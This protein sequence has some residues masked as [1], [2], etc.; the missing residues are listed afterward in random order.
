MVANNLSPQSQ[1]WVRDTEKRIKVLEDENKRLAGLISNGNVRLG[2]SMSARQRIDG[3]HYLGHFGTMNQLRNAV[4]FAVVG[5]FCTIGEPDLAQWFFD[6]GMW[7]RAIYADT[8]STIVG[9][10]AG[11]NPYGSNDSE[12]NGVVIGTQA[13]NAA[14][15]FSGIAIGQNTAQQ[16]NSNEG[17][18]IGNLAGFQ[19]ESGQ[20]SSVVIGRLAG[21][22]AT[23]HAGVSIGQL[24]AS[25]AVGLGSSGI[26]IGEYSG[27]NSDNFSGIAIGDNAGVMAKN[28][29]SSGVFVGLF[30]G[31]NSEDNYNVTY[32]G[33][34][35]GRNVTH[36]QDVIGFGEYAASDGTDLQS[37]IAI[38]YNAVGHGGSFGG[39]RRVIAIG[40]N[41]A[42]LGPT[43]SFGVALT[44]TVAVGDNAMFIAA[45]D[46]V[47]VGVGSAQYSGGASLITAVGRNAA[48][49]A[50]SGVN[51]TAIGAYALGNSGA[52]TNA[53]ALGVNAG[54]TDGT[55]YTTPGLSYATLIG[56]NAQATVNNVF[57]MGSALTAERQTA[58]LGN[59]D[60]LGSDVQ[61]GFAISDAVTPPTVT[62]TGGGILYVE[63][64]ALKYMGSSGT[65]TTLGV[66]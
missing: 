51:T 21:Y 12:L 8:D 13:G 57:V 18:I 59:Y 15:N 49:Q 34:N 22:Q 6:G 24:S 29:N 14:S 7:F 62:P 65:V 55:T 47:A 37:V 60:K 48:N 4:P 5:D 66:A 54:Y 43:S 63:A 3:N 28:T 42:F 53:T 50:M 23:N 36:S 40:D 32:L 31:A 30:S 25:N 11:S 27:M 1:M 41:A 64:G 46:S 61:G 52:S 38:G 16:S 19:L 39:T 33:A 56:A 58:C 2:S 26:T 17:I 45:P 10:F 20:S 9:K 35:S 44:D